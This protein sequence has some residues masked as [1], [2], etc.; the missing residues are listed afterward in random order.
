MTRPKL[1]LHDILLKYLPEEAIDTI[2]DWIVKDSIKVKI[3]KNRFSKL[4]DYRPPQNGFGHR[5]TINHNLNKYAFLITFVHEMAHLKVWQKHNRSVS[6]HGEEW[7]HEFKIALY[8]FL[9][10]NFFPEDV[11]VAL[12]NYIKNPT[13]ASCSDLDLQRVLKKYNFVNVEVLHLEDIPEKTIFQLQT[14]RIFR[15]EEKLRKRFKCTEL[16]SKRT[17]LVHPLAEIELINNT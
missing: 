10:R 2:A 4:G 9:N 6:P 11:L 5:I 14:G 17:F 7:K 1:S 16:S 13:A 12:N 3:T 15:K 8:P